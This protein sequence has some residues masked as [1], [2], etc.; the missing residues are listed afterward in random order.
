MSTF[1]GFHYGGLLFGGGCDRLV[2]AVDLDNP[3]RHADQ[4]LTGLVGHLDA[5]FAGNLAGVHGGHRLTRAHLQRGD[6]LVDL[7]GRLLGTVREVTHLIG[8]HGKP[9]PG[10][11]GTGS[12]DCGVEREQVGL[13][14]DAFDHIEN[15]ADVVG[16]RIQGFDLR[17]GAG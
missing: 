3:L 6:H 8:N 17:A 15:V 12:F 4:A 9:T 5:F 13:L 14:G 16:A 1:E 10:F 7:F 2:H 11:T